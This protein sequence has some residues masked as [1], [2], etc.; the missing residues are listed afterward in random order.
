MVVKQA[1]LFFSS[2]VVMISQVHLKEKPSR[3]ESQLFEHIFEHFKND[4]F[5]CRDVALIFLGLKRFIRLFLLIPDFLEMFQCML[6]FSFLEPNYSSLF[7][8]RFMKI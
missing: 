5:I 7:S 2:S 4:L 1:G 8:L 3:F 6:S